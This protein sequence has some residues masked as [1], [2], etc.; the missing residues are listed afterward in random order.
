MGNK[1]TM[2]VAD[3]RDYTSHG[4]EPKGITTGDITEFMVQLLRI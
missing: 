4:N 1:I 2:Q 3:G